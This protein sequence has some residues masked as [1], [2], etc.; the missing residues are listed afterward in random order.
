MRS[1]VL[2]LSVLVSA[3]GNAQNWPGFRGERANGLGEGKTPT[4]WSIEPSRNIRFKVPVP[5]LAHSSPVIWGDRIF[6]TTA[7][8]A[9]TAPLKVGLYGDIA[10][11][12]NEPSQSWRLLSFDRKTGK[13]LWERVANEGVPKTKRHPKSTHANSTP[14][15]DGE[16]VVA[17][18]GSEGLYCYDFSGKL[19]WKRDFGVLD[20]AF[21]QAPDAQ[22]GFASSP[23]IHDGMVVIQAD[24]LGESFLEALSIED[25]RTIWKTKRSDVPTW[26][27]PNV[28]EGDDGDQILV[29]G[30]KHI[31][32]YDARTGKEIWKLEGGGD[33]PVP[34]PQ[35]AH[36][37]V[38]VTNAHGPGS[39]IFAVRKGARGTIAPGADGT[40]EWIAWSIPQGGAYMQTPL[41]DGDYLY[42]SRD[43]GVLSCFRAKTGELLYRERLGSGSSG[44]SASPVAADGKVY[45]TSEEGQVHVVKAGPAF[46]VLAVNDL[47][48][49]TMATPAVSGGGLYFRTRSSLVAIVDAVEP[50]R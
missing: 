46:E 47:G 15:T 4:S 50:S 24:V 34:T 40:S 2:T 38:F 22:W 36:D 5:G 45:F 23:I 35:V 7:V 26:S 42:S 25:G 13:L 3:T 14:A 11:V 28:L 48:E 9:G 16:R 1:I 39:P 29:N 33:I 20:S 41:I 6:L 31:G 21:F 43:N 19:L 17:F 18:F 32:A 44:F 49:V 10:P 30:W 12:E 8:S 27:T 37:L